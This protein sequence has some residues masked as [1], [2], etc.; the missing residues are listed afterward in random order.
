[1]WVI[2]A[3]R[4]TSVGGSWYNQWGA[5]SIGNV[6]VMILYEE[7]YAGEADYSIQN[8]LVMIPAPGAALLASLGISMITCLR[9]RRLQ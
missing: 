8:Q 3:A 4:A 9:R 6:R 1:M 5:D 7:G 2:E